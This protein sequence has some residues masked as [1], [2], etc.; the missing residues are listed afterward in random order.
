MRNEQM[1]NAYYWAFLLALVVCFSP[2]KALSY[3]APFLCAG[4]L[5]LMSGNRKVR[6][7]FLWVAG[8][9]LTA[10]AFY[11]IV[12]SRF[13]VV[14]GLLA[15]ITY[16]T[17]FLLAI[18]PVR[19]LANK[20]L[21]DR[22]SKL[23]CWALVVEA[24][25]GISQAVVAGLESQS[26]DA[27]NGDVVSGTINPSLTPD[28]GLSNPMFAANVCFML[29]MLIPSLIGK[30][31]FVYIP[32]V[33][34]AVA[35]V[36]ASVMHLIIFGTI[37]IA[38]SYLVF[39]PPIPGLGRARFVTASLL[40]PILAGVLLAGNFGALPD[41]ATSF[42]GGDHPKA[43][44]L[45]RALVEMPREYP[46][47]RFIGLGPGQFSSRAALIATGFYFGGITD[48]KSLPFI[49]EQVSAPL[50]D[51]LL[52]LWIDASDEA[53]YGNSSTAKPFFS[54][55]SVYTEFGAPLF[56]GIFVYCLVLVKRMRGFARTPEQKWLAA[57]AGTGIV[58]FLLMGFQENYWEVPQAV[59]VGLMLVQLL[60]AN[61]V[62][63][64][65]EIGRLDV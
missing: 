21:L 62:Y 42:G 43:E 34:G 28:G 46:A 9:I 11:A 33:L 2:M 49:R 48:P 45:Q 37:A 55:V 39:K 35:F 7:G 29:L 36:L 23:V 18:I 53:R 54:W 8:T 50:S 44:V 12:N 24:S 10:I 1:V 22:I 32:F 16:G 13:I 3:S 56:I 41:F 27:G 65:K 59:L 6:Y 15:G 61:V 30:K 31:R 60:Y 40:I 58:F 25:F 47:M 4:C 63:R 19:L 26:F 38:I 51:Y 5:L 17:Y 52:D 20:N 64:S 57:S 14:G